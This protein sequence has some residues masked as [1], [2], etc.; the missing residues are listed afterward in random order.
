MS[1]SIGYTEQKVGLER[2]LEMV[3]RLVACALKHGRTA[4]TGTAIRD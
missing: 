4:K 3:G 1:H 2:Q